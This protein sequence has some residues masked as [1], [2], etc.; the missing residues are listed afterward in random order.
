MFRERRNSDKRSKGHGA[1]KVQHTMLGRREMASEVGEEKIN[2]YYQ[3]DV[4]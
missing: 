1:E 3:D 4:P 2:G